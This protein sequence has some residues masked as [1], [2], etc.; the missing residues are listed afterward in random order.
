FPL[1]EWGLAGLYKVFGER[2]F[3]HRIYSILIFTL[4]MFAFFLFNLNLKTD[5]KIAIGSGLLLLSV[6]QLYYDS[7]NAMPDILALSLSLFSAYFFSQYSRGFNLGHVIPAILMGGVAGMIKFQFL[8]IPFACLILVTGSFK[9]FIRFTIAGLLCC[10]PVFIWYQY[11]L[12]MMQ[13][14]HLPEFGLWIKPISLSEKLETIKWNLISDIPEMLIGWPLLLYIFYQLLKNKQRLDF[15][16]KWIFIAG[17]LGF[18]VFY[19][20]AIERMGKH[21]YYFIALV[22][23]LVFLAVQLSNALHLKLLYAAIV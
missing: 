19:F 10:L 5:R 2:D 18:I 17:I 20:I 15:K 4:G 23:F 7:L 21:S 14:N 22:P 9:H 12:K 1:Y 11:A 6:P 3:L 8:I 16:S 13:L